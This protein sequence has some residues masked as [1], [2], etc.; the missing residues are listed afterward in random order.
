M[1]FPR[2]S[3]GGL[4]TAVLAMAAGCEEDHTVR[5][6]PAGEPTVITRPATDVGASSARLHAR[7]FPNGAITTVFFE[8][9]A[10]KLETDSLVVGAV[11]D[12][13]D[14]LIDVDQLLYGTDYE[15]HARAFNDFGS[16]LGEVD[17]FTTLVPNGPPETQITGTPPV[18]GQTSFEVI[19][20]WSGSDA[21]GAVIG[22]EWRI[23]DNGADGIIDVGDTLGL[24][25]SFTTVTDSKFVVS[26]DMADFPAN[27]DLFW[28][29]HT[30]F[31]RAV[32]DDDARDPSPAQVSFTATT[33]PPS[34]QIS[35]PIG[36]ASCTDVVGGTLVQWSGDD[37]DASNGMP[38]DVRWILLEGAPPGG[39]DCWTLT[40]FNT[41]DPFAGVSADDPRWS[42]WFD[43]SLNSGVS[44][45]SRPADTAVLLGVQVR[46]AAGATST[47]F[48]WNVE[49]LGLRYAVSVAP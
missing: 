41:A 8:L 27:T 6:Q 40:E 33:Q 2:T 44:L 45:P 16:S 14:V 47:G 10:N 32:D 42:G 1:K 39:G 18:L 35:S 7:V 29:S 43:L 11:R 30:F 28:Q 20:A 17:A 36:S 15:F 38:T 46:D 9:T 49:V 12:T 23:S 21:D 3:W 34:V 5:T 37:P 19:F 48:A 24:D 26:A 31:V 13:L 4:V 25:W 22:Y